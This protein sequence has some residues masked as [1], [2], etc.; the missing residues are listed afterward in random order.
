MDLQNSTTEND[1]PRVELA[2]YIDGELSPRE[3]LELERHFV[4]C[5]TCAS[6]LNEQ[7]RMLCALD[8]AL[9]SERE[10]E[11][12][13]DFTKVIIT[14]ARSN[15]S[16]LR[17]PRERIKA[18]SVCLILFLFAVIGLGGETKTVL[19]TFFTFTEQIFAVVGFVV[20][21]VY[22]VSIGAAIILRSLGNQLVND[23]LVAFASLIAFFF[24]FIFALSRLFVRYNRA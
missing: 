17:S 12:P 9:E 14:N 5:Q 8:F 11:L 2:A 1:C 13:K 6:E 4:V 19:N 23:S 18:I 10:I 21:F 22:D 24:V 3:E 20:H 15:V 16:G 7:K